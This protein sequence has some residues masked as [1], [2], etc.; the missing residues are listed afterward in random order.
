MRHSLCFLFGSLISSV[1]WTCEISDRDQVLLIRLSEA[2]PA[3][4][5]TEVVSLAGAEVP[6]AEI[7]PFRIVRSGGGSMFVLDP[8]RAFDRWGETGVSY[9]GQP[10][11]ALRF[12]FDNYSQSNLLRLWEGYGRSAFSEQE[13]ASMTFSADMML[14]WKKIRLVDSGR[15]RAAMAEKASVEEEDA[16]R[17][18]LFNQVQSY[19]LRND[20]DAV[21]IVNISHGEILK[22][23]SEILVTVSYQRWRGAPRELLLNVP[24]NP[25]MAPYVGF[26]SKVE[27]D[28]RKLRKPLT[29]GGV[30][31]KH[32][33]PP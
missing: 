11:L 17:Y 23:S 24:I 10:L 15:F 32:S 30:R 13:A 29:G 20:P 8:L 12:Y 5:M 18:L 16:V 2:A 28:I 31:P 22:H 7:G 14:Q 19:V 27:T 25:T 4:G 3:A 26:P 21:R 33:G 6:C 1:G 9:S